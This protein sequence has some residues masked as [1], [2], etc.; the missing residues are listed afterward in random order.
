MPLTACSEFTL[1]SEGVS[2][3]QAH[4]PFLTVIVFTSSDQDA[5]VHQTGVAQS[6][7]AASSLQTTQ[8]R[9]GCV[10]GRIGDMIAVCRSHVRS[11]DAGASSP[12]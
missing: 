5:R 7:T 1:G 3:Q 8:G 4:E 11:A 9:K 10:R 2:H 6:Q 12:I